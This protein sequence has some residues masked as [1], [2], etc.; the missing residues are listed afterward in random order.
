[1]YTHM[2]VY[3][4]REDKVVLVYR[5]DNSYVSEFEDGTR[6][7]VSAPDDGDI[8]PSKF[9]IECNG[10]ARVT[11]FTSTCGC[12]LHFPDDSVI[13]CSATG[14]Y[15]VSK[16]DDYELCI[17]S[18]GK[19]AY[20]VPNATYI[21]DHTSV[22]QV[23]HGI[24]IHGNTFSLDADGEASVDA[25]HPIQHRDFDA[26]YFVL[27]ADKSVF[28]VHKVSEVDR[29]IA[30]AVANPKIAI[31]KESVADEP[32]ITSTTLIEP[33]PSSNAFPLTV[34]YQ[35]DSIVPYTLRYGEVKPPTSP[36]AKESKKKLKFGMLVGRGLEIGGYKKQPP[37]LKYVTPIGL[38]YRRFFHLPPLDGEAREQVCDVVA[39]FIS[40]CQEQIKSRQEMQPTEIREDSEVKLAESLRAKLTEPSINVLSSL[41]EETF[42]NKKKKSVHT[43]VPA[44]M[45][46]EG[47]EF[48]EKSKVELQVAE[49]TRIA[50]RHRSIPG[51]FESKYFV[52]YLTAKPPDMAQ[53]TS[54]LAQAPPGHEVG[55]KSQSTL[56]SSSLTLTYDDSADSVIQGELQAGSPHGKVCPTHPAPNHAQGKNTPTD[57]RP[58][59][60]TP[61]KAVAD[62]MATS[63]R[64]SSVLPTELSTDIRE[65]KLDPA[66]FSVTGKPRANTVPTPA[67]LWGGRPGEEPNIQVRT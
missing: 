66:L 35:D 22:E 10:F 55:A 49:D 40:Q 26:H 56:Q 2:Q 48:I 3:I 4:T 15:T 17:E 28:E 14:A 43:V 62:D 23:F 19:A 41:Y 58:T 50:L 47:L 16:A 31:V 45:S 9:V 39:S 60:P 6:F 67:A 38:Q 8:L 1:M 63:H 46:E 12:N 34:S 51:Y 53:L 44:A 37:P 59:N 54:K 18:N 25:P 33:V 42:T 64:F 13:S 52:D 30:E 65:S 27:N 57:V 36:V 61:L 24:D 7:T 21:L 32:S 20:T 5:P 29:I 11:Y